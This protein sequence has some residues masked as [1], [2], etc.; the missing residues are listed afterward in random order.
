VRRCA[1][2]VELRVIGI[3]D[4]EVD[5]GE[6]TVKVGELAHTNPLA[7][8]VAAQMRMAP[9]AVRMN[10]VTEPPVRQPCRATRRSRVSGVQI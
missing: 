5:L 4:A 9:F 1:R 10:S 3:R 6:L 2:L 7:A 8:R